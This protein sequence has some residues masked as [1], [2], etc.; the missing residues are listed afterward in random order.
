MKF[1]HLRF[2][3]NLIFWFCKI[4]F[5]LID[6]VSRVKYIILMMLNVMLICNKMTRSMMCIETCYYG[7]YNVQ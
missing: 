4:Y 7:M 6:R 1:F 5:N 2:S 3:H